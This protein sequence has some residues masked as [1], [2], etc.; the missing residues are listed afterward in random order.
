MR[1][2]TYTL[3]LTTAVHAVLVPRPYGDYDVAVKHMEVIETGVTDLLSPESNATRHTMISAYMPIDRRFSCRSQVVP[4]MPPLTASVMGQVGESLGLP[5]GILEE[6]DMEFCD[7][8]TIPTQHN[9]HK[10]AKKFPVLMYSPGFA[11]SRFIYG[12]L[13]RSLSSLGYVVLTVDHPYEAYVVEFPDG[14]I[15]YPSSDEEITIPQ[16]EVSP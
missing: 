14:T 9:N 6:F 4:Y 13:A 2:Y 12:A 10:T 11:G 15:A 8:E 7:P 1:L 3:L 5:A 16:F